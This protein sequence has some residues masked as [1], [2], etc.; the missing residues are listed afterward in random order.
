MESA[1]DEKNPLHA[2]PLYS[3]HTLYKIRKGSTTN[4]DIEYNGEKTGLTLF[5]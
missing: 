5:I 4:T 2:A 3:V 1:P